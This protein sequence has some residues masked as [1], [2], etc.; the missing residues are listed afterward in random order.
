MR[1][2]RR[3]RLFGRGLLLLTQIILISVFGCGPAATPIVIV[4][5]TSTRPAG[6]ATQPPATPFLPTTIPSAT[7]TTFVPAATIKI[8]SHVPLTGDQAQFGN[9]ILRG[10]QLAIQRLSGPLNEHQIQVELVSYDDQGN[11]SVALTNAQSIITEPE[12]LCGVGHYGSDITIATSD[13]YHQGGLPFVAPAATAPLLTD[14]NY[15]EA[16]RIIGRADGQ[17]TVAGQFAQA[18]RY[19]SAYIITQQAPTSLRNAEAFRTQAGGL[20]IQWLGSV[21]IETTPDSLNTTISKIAS[22]NPA[23]VYISSSADRAMPYMLGLRAA[24][25]TGAFL[26]TEGLDNPP[27]ISQAGPSLLEGGGLYYTISSPPAAYHP[28]TEQFISDY[29]DKYGS[30]PLS[31]AARAYDATGIC[32]RGIERAIEAKGG[33]LPTRNEV[34]RAIRR[35][36]NYEGL[37]GEYDFNREGDPDPVPYY[38]YQV[39]TVD[40]TNWDQNPIIAAYE[41]PP[42]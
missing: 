40:L 17:G 6:E 2:A 33:G 26:G 41:I 27:L 4:L 42:P 37:T 28:D 11:A 19:T 30:P 16:N 35:L 5:P 9:D 8:F 10:T 24:G 38:V 12:I 3:V 18:Q 13:I 20:G 31:F 39:T 32:L 1:S 14:R 7:P 29:T 25:Y 36:N 21:I 15:L 23:V 22:A 34:A